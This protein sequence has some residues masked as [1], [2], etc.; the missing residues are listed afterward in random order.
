MEF[1]ATKAD[2]VASYRE[3]TLILHVPADIVLYLPVPA[4]QPRFSKPDYNPETN[5]KARNPT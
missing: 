4:P 3:K 5:R 1:D 2:V